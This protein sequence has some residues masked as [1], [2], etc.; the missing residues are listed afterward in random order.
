MV[1]ISVLPIGGQ[2]YGFPK[3]CE[4]D[5]NLDDWLVDNG[6]PKERVEYWNKQ[7]GFVPCRRRWIEVEK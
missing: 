7:M 1:K 3:I 4:G 2:Q 5:Q 6:Y